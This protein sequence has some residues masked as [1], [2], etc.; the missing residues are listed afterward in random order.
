MAKLS[1]KK[2]LQRYL[3]LFPNLQVL[4]ERFYC[5]ICCSVVEVHNISTESGSLWVG[6]DG[7][8][9]NKMY[10]DD[11]ETEFRCGCENQTYDEPPG[12]EW[13]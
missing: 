12:F 3:K 4:D 13:F 6:K 8:G 11:S 7:T 1:F 5:T 10:T 9:P 2:Q